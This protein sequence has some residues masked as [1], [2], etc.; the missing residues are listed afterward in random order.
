MGA[1]LHKPQVRKRMALIGPARVGRTGR[2]S[3]EVC[4]WR[5]F[6]ARKGQDGKKVHQPLLAPAR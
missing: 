4:G 1:E 3:E 6:S 5:E 2:I